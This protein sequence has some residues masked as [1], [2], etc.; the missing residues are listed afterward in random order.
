MLAH[1]GGEV[2]R[3]MDICRETIVFEEVADIT[4][5]LLAVVKDKQVVV[6]RI[7]N[8]LVSLNLGP[9]SFFSLF[10]MS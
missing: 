4:R 2:C 1:Y 7:K 5:C 6:E 8:T 10:H 9:P 3:I